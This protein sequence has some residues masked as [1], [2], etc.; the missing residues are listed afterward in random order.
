MD[1]VTWMEEATGARISGPPVL[2]QKLWSGY[3]RIER[4]WLEDG[5]AGRARTVILKVVDPGE[6]GPN[7]PRGWT[8]SF[9]GERKRKSYAVERAYYGRFNGELGPEARTPRLLA[10]AET[11]TGGMMLLE[12]LDPAGFR[13]RRQDV[14]DPEVRA[15]IRWLAAFH[16]AF[17][18]RDPEGLW[19]RGTY[20]HLATRPDEL[21]AT[22]DP[23]LRAAAPAI[24]ARLGAAKHR[25]FV[26]GDAKV[27]NF[28]FGEP[29]DLDI[30]QPVAAVDFQ[31]VGGGIGVQDLS[32]FLGSCL[33]DGQLS[34]RADGYLDAYFA[35]LA[36]RLAPHYDPGAIEAEWRAL[37]PD[38][39]ADF[40]R[41][42]AG[43]APGHWKLSRYSERMVR[44]VL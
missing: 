10:E 20:W 30:H 40:H 7:H 35:E 33:D 9:A 19:D 23:R 43:W 2:V 37:W 36:P 28:C 16:A 1:P 32:Y 26:H 6:A 11:A 8:S 41:F 25:T 31:Y 39:W 12:D 34:Q 17:M 44:S 14:T 42:L 29:A 4:W 15:C 18:G 3:G 38:A 21:A 24:D 13:G 22:Q 5:D 27:A